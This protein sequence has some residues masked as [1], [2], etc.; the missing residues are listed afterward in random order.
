MVMTPAP[1]SRSGKAQWGREGSAVTWVLV[2]H[3]QKLAELDCEDLRPVRHPPRRRARPS[4]PQ[5]PAL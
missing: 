4:T 3:G 2:R 5:C 1:S